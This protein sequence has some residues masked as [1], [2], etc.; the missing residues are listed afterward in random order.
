MTSVIISTCDIVATITPPLGKCVM[1]ILLIAKN[2]HIA[3]YMS[4]TSLS[5]QTKYI[6][7][8]YLFTLNIPLRETCCD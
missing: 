1:A 2:V 3:F 7:D 4:P 5:S 6:M 8:E